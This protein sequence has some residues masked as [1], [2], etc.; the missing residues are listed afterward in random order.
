MIPEVI[1]NVKDYIK[2]LPL[3]GCVFTRLCTKLMRLVSMAI[4]KSSLTRVN[5]F[6][7][8]SQG[9]AFATSS[10][11][12]LHLDALMYRNLVLILAGFEITGFKFSSFI[13]WDYTR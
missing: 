13:F 10:A 7:R 3:D 12:F 4:K 9:F 11:N 5:I 2:V 8:A 1:L 6:D